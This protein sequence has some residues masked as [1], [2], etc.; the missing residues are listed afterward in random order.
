MVDRFCWLQGIFA[1]C[2]GALLKEELCRGDISSKYAG[3]WRKGKKNRRELRFR[4]MDVGQ[5]VRVKGGFFW[6]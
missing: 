2:R 4:P 6:Y 3:K 5:V 1:L